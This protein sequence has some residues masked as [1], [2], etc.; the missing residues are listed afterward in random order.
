MVMRTPATTVRTI[1]FP[2]NGLL[3]ATGGMFA[4]W[5]GSIGSGK[6]LLEASMAGSRGAILG[7]KWDHFPEA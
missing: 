5:L 4:W 1:R 3:L 7:E 2:T 6:P